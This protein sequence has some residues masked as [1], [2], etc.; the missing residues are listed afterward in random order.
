MKMLKQNK[1]LIYAINLKT[2]SL[3]KGKPKIR[4]TDAMMAMEEMR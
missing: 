4:L 2:P 3:C 1:L